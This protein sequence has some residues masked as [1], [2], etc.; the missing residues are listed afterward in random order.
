MTAHEWRRR[1][2]MGM[3]VYALFAFALTV[4]CVTGAASAATISGFYT[5]ISV[6]GAG[7]DNVY[8]PQNQN[9]TADQPPYCV[10]STIHINGSG[11]VSDGGVTAVTIGNVPA[12]TFSVG[13]DSV[14]FAQ[15][16][17]N[18]TTGP[19]T[20]TTP[21][22]TATSGGLN[23]TIW[24]CSAQPSTSKPAIKTI[25]PASAKGGQKVTVEGA[26]LIGITR[27]SVGGVRASY[28]VQHDS[29]IVVV[30]PKTA[31]N[32]ALRIGI[33]TPTGLA[34]AKFTKTG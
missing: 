4:L 27:V 14:L 26:G 25:T 17:P 1:R 24:P 23:E 20:V 33:T 34:T 10:G 29:T 28:S 30:I 32:G 5:S 12:K 9:G 13:S 15:I 16:G 7:A 22:G 11:F 2:A 31:K 8:P 3:R 6:T 18:A 19:V 21:A